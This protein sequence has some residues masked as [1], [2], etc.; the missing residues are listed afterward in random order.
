MAPLITGTDF[1]AISTRDAEQARDFY[2]NVLG[3]E[4]GKQW[5]SMPT[6]EF[7]TG[8]LT[9]AVMQSEAFGLEF[10]AN[11]HPLEFHVDD[12]DTAYAELESR[13]VEFRGDT[14]DSG[15]CKQAFFND[16]D[17]NMLAIHHRYAEGAPPAATAG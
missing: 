16:P 7:E 1:V 2:A 8:N 3:L 6:Y 15:V 5:G 12:F 17:G 13:G 9:I 11:T 14:I 4:Q 10:H